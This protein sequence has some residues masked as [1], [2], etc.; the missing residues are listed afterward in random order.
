[1]ATYIIPSE[2]D[3]WHSKNIEDWIIRSEATYFETTFKKGGAKLLF[4]F[5]FIKVNVIILAPPFLKVD[6]C[7][8]KLNVQR[9]DGSRVFMKVLATLEKS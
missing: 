1:V 9:V 2:K 7:R 3:Q 8:N 6:K 5:H 4:W